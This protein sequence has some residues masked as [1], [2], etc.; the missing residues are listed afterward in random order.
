VED[1]LDDW[2]EQFSPQTREALDLSVAALVDALQRHAKQLG[3]MRGGSR[4]SPAV[5]H[6]NAEVERLIDAWS[7]RVFD[8]TG[9]FPVSLQGFDGDGEEVTE[10]EEDPAE[11]EDGDPLS[12]VSRW[13]LLVVDTDALLQAGR[14]AHRRLRPDENDEDAAVAVQ[15]VGQ[16]VYALL[17][18]RGE[19]W[20]DMPGVEVVNGRRA[21]VRPDEQ[22]P[23]L[24]EESDYDEAITQPPGERLFGEGWR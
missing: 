5:F 7:E 24:S 18:E 13:D 21:Y 8:H 9:T 11:L 19:P 3:G 6:A 12:V 1:A 4:D 17:H 2:P 15:N 20:Y 14:D 16:A 10:D 23:P 22:P